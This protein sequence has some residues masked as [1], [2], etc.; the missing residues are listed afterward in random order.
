MLS[1]DAR[2]PTLRDRIAEIRE[3]VRRPPPPDQ[4]GTRGRSSGLY[5]VQPSAAKKGKPD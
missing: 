5:L 3:T 4:S 2:A 1:G